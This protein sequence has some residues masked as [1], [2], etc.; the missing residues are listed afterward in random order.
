MKTM[1]EF[2]SHLRS[3]GVKL[4]ADGD[5]LRYSALK[6]TLTPALRAELAERKADILTLLQQK[7]VTTLFALPPIVPIARD[8]DLPLSFAQ[9]R[10]WLL[11]CLEPEN[12]VYN[13]S[14]AYRLSGTLNVTALEQSLNEIVRRH[15]VLRITIVEVDGVPFQRISPHCGLPLLVIEVS[16]PSV[17]REE[18]VL[19]LAT[20]N[21]T[22]PLDWARGSRFRAT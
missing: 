3:L 13:V 4:W 5:R 11:N 6:G 16:V 1:N 19:L 10:L 8:G 17:M 7:P 22:Q 21:M 12:S 18:R 9:Q 15:E 2:L 14:A 20:D